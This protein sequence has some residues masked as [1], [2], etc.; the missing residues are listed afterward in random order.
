MDVGKICQDCD[1]FF[2]LAREAYTLDKHELQYIDSKCGDFA[3]KNTI[4]ALQYLDGRDVL[5]K[6]DNIESLPDYYE[7]LAFSYK[8]ALD[9]FYK[10]NPDLRIPKNQAQMLLKNFL[11]SLPVEVGVDL[12]FH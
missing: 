11:S 10:D 7:I 6:Y 2:K 3:K 1:V 5:S 12:R 9:V 8:V 4:G